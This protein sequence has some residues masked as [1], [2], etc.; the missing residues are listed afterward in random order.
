M[1]DFKSTT[2]SLI[3]VTVLI[4]ITAISK[5]FFEITD[6]LFLNILLVTTFGNYIQ[7]YTKPPKKDEN[8]PNKEK[9]TISIDAILW[10]LIL[11]AFAFMILM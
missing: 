1:L 3:G 2:W 4:W 8:P 9:G 6:D 11:S 10:I 7:E 5:V